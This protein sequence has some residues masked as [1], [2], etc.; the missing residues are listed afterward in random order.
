M[1]KYLKEDWGFERIPNNPKGYLSDGGKIIAHAVITKEFQEGLDSLFDQG[2]ALLS[3]LIMAFK[4]DIIA[5]LNRDGDF[6]TISFAE[7]DEIWAA[8]DAQLKQHIDGLFDTAIQYM[9]NWKWVPE[10]NDP[11]PIYSSGSRYLPDAMFESGMINDVV[12]QYNSKRCIYSVLFSKDHYQLVTKYF[13]YFKYMM[14]DI[15]K[16]KTLALVDKECTLAL[17]DSNNGT[18]PS[19]DRAHALGCAAMFVVLNI[20]QLLQLED[21]SNGAI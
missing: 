8:T 7:S 13:R 9:N 17:I 18:G 1:D 19:I 15:M 12:I 14:K 20:M 3:N 11:F 2:S 5:N 16:C 21:M 6:I 4:M 10:P